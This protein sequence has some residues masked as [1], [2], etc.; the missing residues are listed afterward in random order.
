MN[1]GK[2]FFTGIALVFAL[3]LIMGIQ[4]VALAQDAKLIKLHSVGEEALTGIFIDPADAY[5]KKDTI[6]V[7]LSGVVDN[8]VKI[9]FA[10][11]KKCKSV[12]AHNED[13]ELDQERWCYVTSFVP[14]ASTS[15]LQFTDHG[16][17]E[18]TVYTKSGIKAK[19]KIIVE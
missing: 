15:S 7:W 3:A 13:F 10:D 18:Y 4:G 6:V 11:G 5:V 19:G 14:F 8:E 1:K 16:V 2:V 12:I 17:Y 9:E